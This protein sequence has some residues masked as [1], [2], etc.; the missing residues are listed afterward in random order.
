MITCAPKRMYLGHP[1]TFQ[2]ADSVDA[3]VRGN[4]RT[5]ALMKKRSGS[6]PTTTE[7]SLVRFSSCLGVL[8]EGVVDV[9]FILARMFSR[10]CRD[11]TGSS[12]SVSKVLKNSF[13]S[14]AK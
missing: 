6:L 1:C 2:L 7:A 4:M 9:N 13:S 3:C 12:L 14:A 10:G 11:F 8:G 5:F